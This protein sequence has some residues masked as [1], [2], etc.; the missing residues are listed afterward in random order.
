MYVFNRSESN[1]LGRGDV[2]PERG[3]V[4][5]RMPD[6]AELAMMAES[7]GTDAEACL[8]RGCRSSVVGGV[9]VLCLSHP[10]HGTCSV[11]SVDSV[12]LHSHHLASKHHVHHYFSW[13]TLFVI[14]T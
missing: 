3:L 12:A 11:N 6:N 13:A 1:L 10:T 2:A 5:D 8:W 9:V 4:G 7:D 14:T